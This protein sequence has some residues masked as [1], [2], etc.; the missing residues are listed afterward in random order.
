[1]LFGNTV[2]L[3]ITLDKDLVSLT[4]DDRTACEIFLNAGGRRGA[5]DNLSE[6]CLHLPVKEE[7]VGFQE[8][9]V[10]HEVWW[11][12]TPPTAIS[13]AEMAMAAAAAAAASIGVGAGA[14]GVGVGVGMLG[15]PMAVAADGGGAGPIRP[16]LQQPLTPVGPMAPYHHHPTSG[17][18]DET[19]ALDGGGMSA[20]LSRLGNLMGKPAAAG[21]GDGGLVGGGDAL[22]GG[23]RIGGGFGG[24]LG[25]LT[26]G[27][28]DGMAVVA[29]NNLPEAA[30]ETEVEQV[31]ADLRSMFEGVGSGQGA[32][33]V[34]YKMGAS[35]AFVVLADP[36][37]LA[38]AIRTLDWTEYT[39]GKKLRLA[40]S[41][42][43]T[44]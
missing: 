41:M 19:S 35:T 18:G 16:R 40:R 5:L 2:T 3:Q 30:S 14:D 7:T 29:V 38:E 27:G 15:M 34:H 28:G 8:E 9:V 39:G 25:G 44:F 43:R 23:G 6:L 21:G 20:K 33:E 4:V 10:V 17:Y 37:D 32:D 36:Q 42:K 1:M 11:S 13:A 26:G 24:L 12:P 22:G 31:K